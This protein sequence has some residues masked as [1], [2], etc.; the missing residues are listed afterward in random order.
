MAAALS[1]MC[2]ERSFRSPRLERRPLA[3]ILLGHPA[4]ATVVTAVITSRASAPVLPTRAGAPAFDVATRALPSRRRYARALGE[5]PWTPLAQSPHLID[6]PDVNPLYRCFSRQRHHRL[7]APTTCGHRSAPRRRSNRS[8]RIRQ[9]AEERGRMSGGGATYLTRGGA[10]STACDDSR[11]CARS[12]GPRPRVTAISAPRDPHHCPESLS[13]SRPR[14]MARTGEATNRPPL[15]PQVAPPPRRPVA[16][17]PPQPPAGTASLE[18]PSSPGYTLR[19]GLHP[20]SA[21]SRTFLPPRPHG[22]SWAIDSLVFVIGGARR[23]YILGSSRRTAAPHSSAF[24]NNLH[25]RT[26]HKDADRFSC[27]NRRSHR[28]AGAASGDSPTFSPPAALASSFPTATTSAL[29]L[30]SQGRRR[31]P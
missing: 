13:G 23:G 1:V 30:P 18:A 9:G 12:C 31:R 26:V 6:S 4:A 27:A 7:G 15:S 28:I 21:N 8:P 11:P 29:A 5:V 16:D 2:T 25:T 14:R 19:G 3:P 24:H 10:P 20:E 17:I 22:G